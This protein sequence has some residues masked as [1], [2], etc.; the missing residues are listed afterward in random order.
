MPI[1]SRI[2]TRVAFR[3]AVLFSS[4]A[5]LAAC[6][7]NPQV[8]APRQPGSAAGAG[9][10]DNID[11]YLLVD[12]LLPGQIR[13]LGRAATYVSARPRI[14]TTKSD[15]GIRG[16]EFVLFDRADYGSALTSLL[17]KAR[18]GDVVAQTYVGEIYEKGLGLAQPDYVV[19]AMWYERAARQG[20]APAQTSLGVLYER[21]LG[22][23]KDPLRALDLYRGAAGIEGDSLVFESQLKAER[24]AFQKE[25]RARDQAAVAVRQR[26]SATKREL[27]ST[28]A[29]GNGARVA[30]LE[31]SYKQQLSALE[32][33]RRD[34]EARARDLQRQELAARS[35]EKAEKVSAGPASPKVA[36]AG[37]L[38]LVRSEQ[39]RAT[40][41]TAN[42]LVSNP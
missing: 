32:S 30:A 37:K 15:C 19:A 36:R 12:C 4:L 10:A 21:G 9:M 24:A 7:S 42:R 34:A 18:A 22:V 25:L 16:G 17:P 13:Q 23:G 40:M 5:V 31:A 26:L 11:Q 14:K 29:S 39:Y 3:P 28:R 33:Q 8:D 1:L 6:T 20:H 27:A 41:A 38:A 35:V 2:K